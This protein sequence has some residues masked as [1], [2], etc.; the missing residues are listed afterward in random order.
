[1]N[2]SVFHIEIRKVRRRDAGA[3]FISRKNLPNQFS[4]N[5]SFQKGWKASGDFGVE[6][7]GVIQ[8]GEEALIT[9][10][11]KVKGGGKQNKSIMK[12]F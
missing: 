6:E 12:N 3:F 2:Q 4:S 7:Q 9:A 1:M 8:S 11:S 10:S 5:E